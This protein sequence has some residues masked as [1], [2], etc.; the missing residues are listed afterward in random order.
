MVCQ[1][2]GAGEWSGAKRVHTRRGRLPETEASRSEFQENQS[3]DESEG[4]RIGIGLS[5]RKP[6]ESLESRMTKKNL[7]A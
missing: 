7:A 2:T 5:G 1:G 6:V 4:G 3:S